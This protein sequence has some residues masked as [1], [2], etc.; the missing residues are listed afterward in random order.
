ME[1]QLTHSHIVPKCS[2]DVNQQRPSFNLSVCFN[3]PWPTP[4]TL[5]SQF[6]FGKAVE[7]AD[8]RHAIQGDPHGHLQ[9]GG[10]HVPVTAESIGLGM[11]P[12]FFKVLNSAQSLTHRMC[13]M[14]CWFFA[15]QD[16]V[17][18][19]QVWIWATWRL[20]RLEW[21]ETDLRDLELAGWPQRPKWGLGLIE[22]TKTGSGN[23][24]PVL[25]RIDG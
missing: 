7:V 9:L 25:N 12:D 11:C 17:E 24:S 13:H 6:L 8:L 1:L 20:Y 14:S 3:R 19:C 22:A 2:K 21:F 4:G 15:R 16:S 10:R 5:P 18:I 23:Q